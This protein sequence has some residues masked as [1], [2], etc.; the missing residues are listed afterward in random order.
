MKTNMPYS[1][2][3]GSQAEEPLARVDERGRLNVDGYQEYQLNKTGFDDLKTIHEHKYLIMRPYLLSSF[4][5][6]S[7][8]DIGCSAGVMGLQAI[9]DTC[10]SVHF[11]DH[12]P[13]YIEVVKTALKYLDNN[14]S[15]VN[16]SPIGNFALKYEV[17]IALAVIH[18]IY[19]YSEK[20]GSLKQSVEMLYDICPK[21]LFIEWVSPNDSAILQAS[22]TEKNKL[23]QTEAYNYKNFKKA[24]NE[25]YP[26]TQKIGEV[27]STRELWLASSSPIFAYPDLLAESEKR[28]N[29]L[30][31]SIN[32][33]RKLTR[34]LINIFA[35]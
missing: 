8:L 1:R 9:I 6:N 19:S 11:L 2:K 33:G 22:H 3:V 15:E 20:A 13:E 30:N 16:C 4:R 28:L 31:R 24:L 14:S 29:E 21:A 34:R 35:R 10:S 27:N 23:E 17:G 7:V 18:W 26:Y 12:D 5:D 32:I 25:F